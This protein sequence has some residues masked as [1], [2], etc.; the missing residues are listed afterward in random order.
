[1][2]YCVVNSPEKRKILFSRLEKI[3][4]RLEDKMRFIGCEHTN[5]IYV[6]FDGWRVKSTAEFRLI[7]DPGE[8]SVEEFVSYIKLVS[9]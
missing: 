6:T 9:L 4:K 5:F 7:D 2:I 8:V 3:T 1:M